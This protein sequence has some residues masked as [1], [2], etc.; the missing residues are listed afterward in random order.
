MIDVN[1]ILSE[2]HSLSQSHKIE[3]YT[4]FF[5]ASKGDI[6]ENDK[7]LAIPVPALRKLVKKYYKL[8][9]NQEIVIFLKSEYNDIR[10]FGQQVIVAKYRHCDN[11]DE[12]Y[13]LLA[14]LDQHI[15]S[16]NHWNLVDALAD[17]FGKF[18]LETQDFIF[19]NKYRYS[20]SIWTKRLSIVACL[21]LVKRDILQPALD[22]IQEHIAFPHEYIHKANG[23][24]LRE[25]SKKNEKIIIDFLK[26]NWP[27]IPSVTKSYA[28]ERL[29]KTYDIKALFS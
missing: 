1:N 13:E 6:C 17:I 3:L 10:F 16:V 4:K 29:R 7:I 27:N 24:I 11:I 19:I 20:N 15:Y 23:W 14:F 28:T 5:R 12:K 2:I 21:T 18:A 26:K 25:I 9:S 8:L 22:I